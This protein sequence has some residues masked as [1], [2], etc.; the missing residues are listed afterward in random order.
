MVT[1][2]TGSKFPHAK[3]STGSMEKYRGTQKSLCVCLQTNCWGFLK[4]NVPI[5][6]CFSL[7]G[8]EEGEQECKVVQG[9]SHTCN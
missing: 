8:K 9:S 2:S 6:A 3:L 1:L 4:K 5:A 7:R